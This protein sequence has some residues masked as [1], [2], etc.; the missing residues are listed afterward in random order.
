MSTARRA[1]VI[2]PFGRKKLADGTE[3]D[4]DDVYKRLLEPAIAAAGLNPHRADADR[5]GGSIHL[6]MFQDLLLSEFVVADLTMDNPNVWYEIGVRH[7]LRSGGTVMTY[8]A[9][10]R[11]PFDIAGQRMQRYT[12]KD[13]KLDPERLEA[14]CSALKE[15]IVATLGAWRGRR[16]SPV[17]QQIP[18][19]REPDWKTLKVGDIN[20]YW[21]ALDAW[22]T[23]IDVARQKQRPG[24]IL[25]LAD[26][27]PNSLL[28]FEALRTAADALLRMNRPR[29]ALK[30]LEQARK[31]DP[32]DLRAKQ[33][34]GMALGRDERFEEARALLEDLA[35]KNQDGETQGIF[36]RTWKDEWARLWNAHPQR[37]EDPKAAAQDTAATLNSAAVAYYAAFRAAPADYYP[38][39]NALTLGRLWEHV[40]GEKSG[41]PLDAIAQGVGWTVGVAVERNKDYW[42]LVT[43]AEMAL[44]EGRKD[45]ALKDYADAAALAVTKR[46]RF[47]LDSS[48]QQ[49]DFLGI[50][51]FRPEIVA[52]AAKIIDRGER[53][54]DAL[55]GGRKATEP[56]PQRVVV[57]SGHMIDDPA[58]RGPGKAKAA[59]F[60]PEK[61]DAVAAEIRKRLDKVGAAAGDVGL[62]GG[63]S[64]G[65]L[66]F[67]EACLERGM[68]MELRL[69][70]TEPE[71]LAESVTFADPDG[72]WQDSFD[73]VR[74]SKA[75]TTFIMPQ[76]LG[77]AP[78]GV[79]VHDRCNRWIL[80]S[81]LSM[82]LRKTSFITLW[83]GEPGDGP[84]GTQHMVK[85]VRDLTGRR[86]EIIDP[87][88]V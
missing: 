28:E 76:E 48:S 19:L 74:E 50:L 10:D 41:L 8:A 43:R 60:P 9:R 29:Y 33:L 37:A 30:I 70:R 54:L 56:E 78:E 38:G 69:A 24:D 3:V 4:C 14:E 59:R 34:E 6:D 27:T 71:F 35:A 1:F 42:S 15:A 16:A 86:P 21:Q 62:C 22:R 32:D 51:G 36:A 23:R 66:L 20:E 45:Q 65:D 63:A 2:M 80:Y 40:T 75:T 53:Q 77:P 12:L 83:N 79:S 72:R 13:G 82:G 44:V 61:I 46:E 64:G 5:R 31:L 73:R 68:R 7:A 57:F 26:E 11:L 49:L 25:I 17:Y 58:V 18:S 55:I 81:A 88:T 84:G 85:L 39:I 52:E 87:K 47:W 67:A